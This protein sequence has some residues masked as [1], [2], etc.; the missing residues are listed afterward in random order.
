ME[1]FNEFKKRLN[2]VSKVGQ[3]PFFV[4]S[5]LWGKDKEELIR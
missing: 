3:V 2:V 5:K 1:S 4:K